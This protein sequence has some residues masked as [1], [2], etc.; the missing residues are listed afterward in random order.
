MASSASGIEIKPSDDFLRVDDLKDRETRCMLC[1]IRGTKVF[2]TTLR[3]HLD[4]AHWK[5]IDG[6]FRFSDNPLCDVIY[7]SN[8]QGLYFLKSEVRTIFGPKQ[9]DG[10]K[11]LC[12]CLGVTEE[13]IRHEIFDKKCCDSLDAVE[14]YTKAGTGR[15]CFV[16][17][18]SGRCCREYLPRKVEGYLKE[19]RDKEA[20]ELLAQVARK[21]EVTNMSQ[22]KV[23]LKVSGMTCESCAATVRA[24]LEE[25]GGTGI[26][27]FVPEGKASA[28]F[29]PNIQAMEAAR[30]VT[31]SGYEA[32]V[33]RS[34]LE[35]E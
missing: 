13:D 30:A 2:E 7:F 24:A 19:A 21:L 5:R 14:A 6:T 34:G 20:T 32:A 11:P 27:I 23:E 35:K 31:D 10:I 33:D 29:P 12:Y 4:P 8:K 15:W 17:N 16:T 28:I 26:E 1:G 9:K 22:N 18:P 25:L 3:N